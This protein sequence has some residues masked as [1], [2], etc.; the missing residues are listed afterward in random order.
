VLALLPAACHKAP[1]AT[2]SAILFSLTEEIG[3]FDFVN[4]SESAIL[5]SLTECSQPFWFC[6]Q[7]LA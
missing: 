2:Q 4:R 5:L 3:H 7:L 1:A 6:V